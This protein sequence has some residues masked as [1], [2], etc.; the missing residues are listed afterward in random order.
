MG[1]LITT[2]VYSDDFTDNPDNTDDDDLFDGT[3]DEHN[4]LR[5][6]HGT[7]N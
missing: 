3:G 1:E 6:T 2:Q 4:E 7:G 5:A